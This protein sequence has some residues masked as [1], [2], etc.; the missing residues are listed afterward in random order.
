MIRVSE[1]DDL[2]TLRA[3]TKIAILLFLKLT[4]FRVKELIDEDRAMTLIVEK[5]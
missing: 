4:G 5:K 3:F 1:F 2:T